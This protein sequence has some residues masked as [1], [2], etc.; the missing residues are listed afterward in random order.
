VWVCF[1]VGTEE[2]EGKQM[3]SD[4]VGDGKGRRRGHTMTKCVRGAVDT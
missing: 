3:G 4:E 2:V 1:R